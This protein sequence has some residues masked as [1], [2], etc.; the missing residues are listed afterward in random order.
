[1]KQEITL[2]PDERLDEVNENLR[3]IQKTN[4]L[5]FGTDAYLLAAFV[6]P[7]PSSFA[8]ELGGGVQRGVPTPE[9][10]L[11]DIRG[12]RRLLSAGGQGQQTQHQNNKF[13]H[14]LFN[15]QYTQR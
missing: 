5:T 4:G 13:F 10:H 15:R 11:N 14:N 2:L 9:R 8:V 1:M 3:L 7:M 12:R 6:R